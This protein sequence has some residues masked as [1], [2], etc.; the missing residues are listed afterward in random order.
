MDTH[1]NYT[2]AEWNGVYNKE[3]TVQLNPGDWW[4]QYSP[5]RF[6]T[7][8]SRIGNAQELLNLES[9]YV[10]QILLTLEKFSSS[11]VARRSVS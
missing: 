6:E 4:L 7:L 1:S 9:K 2:S 11:I 3:K 5:S 10:Y 8:M